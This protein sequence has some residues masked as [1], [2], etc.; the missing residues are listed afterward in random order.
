MVNLA[1]GTIEELEI[2]IKDSTGEAAAPLATLTS[3]LNKLQKTTEKSF[4]GLAAITSS[5]AKFTTALKNLDTAGVQKIAQIGTSVQQLQKISNTKI[6]SNITSNITALTSSLAGID[7]SNSGKITQLVESL[8]PLST[9]SA[10]GLNSYISQLNKIPAAFAGL[11]SIDTSK[12]TELA[13]ALKP[14]STLD[15]SKLTSYINQLKKLLTVMGDFD[16]ADLEKF[17]QQITTLTNNLKPFADEM[18]KISA[19]FNAMPTKIQK[20]IT[21]TE[22]YNTAMTNT[23]KV[24]VLAAGGL[25]TLAAKWYLVLRAVSFL[26]EMIVKSNEYQENLNLFTASMGEYA[27]SAME[28]AEQVERV[29]GI[30]PSTWIRN[31]GVFMTLAT[32]LGVANDQAAIMSQNLTQLGYDIAS[33]YN[34]SVDDAMQKVQSALAG[35]LEPVR[36]LGYALSQNSLQEVYDTAVLE[37]YKEELA[38]LE[39]ALS[40]VELEAIA[41][42]N[43]ISKTMAQMTEAEKV[44]VRYIALMTQNTVVQGDMSRTL[45][46]P[47]NQLRIL[48][49]Q[50]AMTARAIGNIFI[51]ALNQIL[52]YAIAVVYAIREVANALAELFGFQ[53]AEVDYSGLGEMASGAEDLADGLDDAAAS[54]A[55]AFKFMLPFDELNVLDDTP[56][57]SNV[58]FGFSDFDFNADDYS[59]DFLGDAVSDRI[60]AIKAK[61]QPFI[62]WII[63]HLEEILTVIK[64]IGIAWLAW[65]IGSAA[66]SGLAAIQQGLQTIATLFASVNWSSWLPILGLAAGFLALVVGINGALKDGLDLI[67]AILILVGSTAIGAALAAMIPGVTL[68]FGALVGSIAGLFVILGLVIWENWDEITKFFGYCVEGWGLILEDWGEWAQGVWSAAV[69]FFVTI[70]E[71]LGVFFSYLWEGLGLIAEDIWEDICNAWEVAVVVFENGVELLTDIFDTVW[72]FI[73]TAAINAWEAISETWSDVAGWFSENVIEPI[74]KFFADMWLAIADLATICWD[75]ICIVWEAVS[76]WFND[77]V[78][79]PLSK[80]WDEA[81]N[82]IKDMS[83]DAWEFISN[84]WSAGATWFYDNVIEPLSTFFDE[85][86]DGIGTKAA[87]A[88][89]GMKTTFSGLKDWFDAN[90]AEPISATFS[91]AFNAVR[92]TLNKMIDWMNSKLSVTIPAV[93]ML[94][95]AETSITLV[96]IPSIP[97]F[98]DG[99]FPDA[100]QLF[101]ANEAGAEMVGNLGGRTAVANNDQIVAGVSAGVYE[102]VKAAMSET[103]SQQGTVTVNSTAYLDGQVIYRN[104][105]NIKAKRGQDIGLGVFAR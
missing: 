2:K 61:L 46:A 97:E 55:E 47:A 34:L 105:E 24:N 11:E 22:K 21:S 8:Q 20:L 88:W 43:G 64:W 76:T 75:G 57:S 62:D 25:A 27:E 90:I 86:W 96:T 60:D 53:L 79:E 28:F 51:P 98:A 1:D 101:I 12:T 36:R 33:F 18:A 32:G 91:N 95:L 49:E 58:D 19:G 78:I 100:G 77:N 31:Q 54:A 13:D 15:T 42:A 70:W 10:S 82:V 4:N 17:N 69:D 99:G 37:Q 35:E 52:P 72:E 44:Q 63:E 68:A 81:W 73:K 9:M 84:A 92:A 14:L 102:A 94:G 38:K 80:H 103:Q 104:Q 26:G 89:E 67:D 29:M 83:S 66:I 56:S 16:D 41:A 6:N 5:L 71:N 39:T 50:L 85:L 45:E 74:S 3:A 48:Q 23:N 40:D 93:P 30:D 65:N 87:N 7:V 59:Y